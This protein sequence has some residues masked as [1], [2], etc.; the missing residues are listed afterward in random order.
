MT[1]IQQAFKDLHRATL[2]MGTLLMAE[3]KQEQLTPIEQALNGGAK[4]VIEIGPLPDAQLV[5]IVCVEREGRR[6]VVS[7]CTIERGT[8]Q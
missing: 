4:L 1:D 2:T 3:C 7:Q 8:I 5:Q 6:H